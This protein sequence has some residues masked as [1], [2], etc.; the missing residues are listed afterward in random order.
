MAAE[1]IRLT[2]NRMAHASEILDQISAKK[3]RYQEIPVTIRYSAETL[4]KGQKNSA[5]FRVAWDVI[6]GN[7]LK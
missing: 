4:A 7:I 3:L 1:R 5:M 6:K 2:Q